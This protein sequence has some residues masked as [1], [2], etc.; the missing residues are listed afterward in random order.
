MNDIRPPMRCKQRNYLLRVGDKFEKFTRHVST[1][2][3]KLLVTPSPKVYF[4]ISVSLLYSIIQ[5][6][7]KISDSLVIFFRLGNLYCELGRPDED[8]K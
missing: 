4:T 7:M 3:Y 1:F 8:Q 6:E 2:E 5:L